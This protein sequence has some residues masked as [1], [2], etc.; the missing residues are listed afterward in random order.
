MN[1]QNNNIEILSPAGDI[2]CFKT[3][4]NCGADA[5][6]IGGQKFSARKNA[7]NFTD[8]QI[9]EAVVYAHLRNTK[10][11]AAVNTCVFEN[12]LSDVFEYLKFLY[13]INTDGVIIQ[14]LGI[15]NIVKKYFPDMRPHASTQMTVH[16]LKGALAAKKLGFKRVVLSR[17]LSLDEIKNISQNCGIETEVFVHGALCM[18][19][20]GQCLMSSFIGGRSGNRGLCAQPCRLKYTLCDK[21]KNPLSQDNSYLMSLKDLCLIEYISKLKEASVTSLKIEG[22]MKGAEYVA[23][24]TAMYN[25]YRGGEKPDKGD[26]DMLENIFSRSGFTQGYINNNTGRH[27]LNYQNSNDNVYNMQKDEVVNY[28]KELIDKKQKKTAVNLKFTAKIGNNMLLEIKNDTF[29]AAVSSQSTVQKAI[30]TATLPER[31]IQ[32]LAKTG[33]TAFEAKNIELDCDSGINIPIKELNLLRRQAC[34]ELQ[35]K[36]TGD[37]RIYNAKPYTIKKDL[38]PK[39]NTEYTAEVQNFEQAKKAYELGFARIYI[40]YSLYVRHKAEFDCDGDVY[41]VKLSNIQRDIVKCDVKIDTDTV[42]VSNIGQISEFAGKKYI[43]TDYC[44]NIFNSE[45]QNVL[46]N[47]G[48]D[49]VCMSTEL[50]IPQIS[51]ASCGIPFEIPVYGRVAVMTVQNCVVKSAFGKCVCGNNKDGY[52]LLKDR[53]GFYFPVFTHKGAC[54]DTIYN[55]VPIYMGDRMGELNGLNA[56]H[57]RFIFTTETPGEIEK[58]IKMYDGGKKFPDKNFTRG[59]FYNPVL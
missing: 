3:A 45:A 22:R 28:A 33:D 2:D 59:H 10:V 27:M 51:D 52:Y 41:A 29:C 16:N 46:K 36:I 23:L 12:E 47:M 17:E 53:K 4:V 13:S 34:E 11:Y 32:Q 9:K 20:S 15:L 57:Y 19:Y 14:D 49:E 56:A 25:K 24:A 37:V 31:I 5:V 18:S 54:F 50:T 30:K 8:E 1:N 38:P 39:R 35:R 21:D 48:A 43:C 44:M 42:C 6:Y 40:P 55:S 26:L 58:I 7:A